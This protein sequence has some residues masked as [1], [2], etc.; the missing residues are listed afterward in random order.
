MFVV[1]NK[2][3]NKTS[4]TKIILSWKSMGMSGEILKP[5]NNSTLFPK[6][7]YPYPD[8]VVKFN[9]SCL[10]KEDKFNFDKKVLKIYI[11][12]EIDNNSNN[13][14]PKLKNCLFGSKNVTKESSDFNEQILSGYGLG[15]YTDYVFRYSP[16]V[17]AYNAIIFGVDNPE[18][19]NVLAIG[20]G[21]VKINNKMA[22]VKTSNKN[23]ISA[24]AAKIVLSLHYNKKNSYIYM[25][26]K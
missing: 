17:F 12:Y 15:F 23:N 18:N 20:K 6:L 16:G 22:G 7:E 2:Y 8:M 11:F 19:R 25:V 4:R 10:V 13:F 5:L 9:G 1:K 3:F 26:I 14:Y 21:N 24:P